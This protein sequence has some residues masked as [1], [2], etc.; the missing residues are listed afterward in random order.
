MTAGLTAWVED[1]I[2]DRL[3]RYLW[4][5][6][7]PIGALIL[8]RVALWRRWVLGAFLS[9]GE[10]VLTTIALAAFGLFPV[11]LPATTDPPHA[12][13]VADA[14]AASTGLRIGQGWWVPGMILVV[15][16]FVFVYRG[17]AGKIFSE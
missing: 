3:I 9:S 10:F 7:G 6:V 11:L 16:Y 13:T 5:L 15:G 14:A 12:L 4:V 2:R 8:V 1:H 17:F